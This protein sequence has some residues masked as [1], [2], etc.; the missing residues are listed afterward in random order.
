MQS[1]LDEVGTQL[2]LVLSDQPT[3]MGLSRARR[4]GVATQILPTRETMPALNRAALDWT[5]IDGIL[6]EARIDAIFLL[7]FMRI[8]PASFIARW[9]GRILNLHPS[10]LPLH[11]G[12]DVVQKAYTAGDACGATVHEVVPEIDAGPIVRARRSVEPEQLRRW[13]QPAVE[14][15]VHIDEQRLVKEIARRWQPRHA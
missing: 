7:G 15:L 8:V 6:R 13:S 9:Q 5:A 14:Q 10:L 4:S 1:M 12:L 3:A 2:R 11:P